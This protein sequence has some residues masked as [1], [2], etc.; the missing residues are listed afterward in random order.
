MRRREFIAIGGAAM[1]WPIA[2]QAQQASKI[3]RIG[4]LGPSLNN[5]PPVAHYQAFLSQLAR[6]CRSVEGGVASARCA[7]KDVPNIR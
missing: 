7:L 3:V 2:V 4:F 6:A 1:A 5:P